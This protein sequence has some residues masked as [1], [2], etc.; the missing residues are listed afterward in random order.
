MNCDNKNPAKRRYTIRTIWAA[1]LC[2]F[3]ALLA[4][5]GFH[6]WHFRGAV[7]WMVAV[8]PA[9]PIVAALIFTALYLTEEKDEFQRTILTQSLL[10]GI[11]GTLAVTTVWGYLEGFALAPNLDPIWVY[12]I[13]TLFAGISNP[14]VR[15]R[16]R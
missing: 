11:G 2:V 3:F 1:L 7:A 13:F 6:F 16:Y 12:P 9:L 15:L 10:W 5:Y 8:L 4:K 14:M